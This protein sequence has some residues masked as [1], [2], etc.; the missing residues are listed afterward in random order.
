MAIQT[1][2]LEYSD[3]HDTMIGVLVWD[4]AGPAKRAG[5][6][7]APAYFGRGATED[8]A[9]QTLAE[10]G[11]VALIVD[12]YGNGQQ[13]TSDTEAG[14]L[15]GF[16]NQ[17]RDVFARRMNAALDTLKVQDSV[18]PKRVGAMGFCL[19]GKAV[20]DLARSGADFQA[21]VSLHGVYDK[22][23]ENTDAITPAIL[24]LHGWDDPLA[25]PSA[26]TG[27][28]EE[29]TQRCEDWQ[30]LA[31]GQ[32]SHAYTNPHAQ[33]P[34]YGM[35]FSQRSTDRSWAATKTLFADKLA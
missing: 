19:G 28:A 22:P 20:L 33:S 1:K 32:T 15:M 21:A 7:V 26:V 34:D 14:E 31:F 30:L 6:L 24:A 4:D 29:L 8:A 25:P 10:D 3:G 27:L 18:D 23:N 35:M 2:E 16:V 12:Y 11:Y 13:A 9:A 5:V 17:N